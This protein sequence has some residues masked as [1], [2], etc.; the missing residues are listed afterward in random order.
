[1]Q[2]LCK[3][4]LVGVSGSI[5]S[6]S[7]HM[8]LFAF[9]K[10]FAENIKVIM[11]HSAVRMVNPSALELYCDDRVFVDTWDKSADVKTP[12][13][14]L[15]SWADIF[16][17]LPATANILGKAANGVA[18]DLLS[19]AIISSSGT[20]VFAPAMNPLMWAN[21][22]VQRNL[23]M[24]KSDGHYIITPGNGVSVTTRRWDVG[25]TVPPPEEVLRHLQ[26]VRMKTLKDQYWDE[27]TREKPKTPIQRKLEALQ[28]QALDSNV[29]G[30]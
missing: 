2:G 21:K 25:L 22:A 27:A 7:I 17:V 28:E 3:N 8:Y 20:I 19:T 29:N 4:L 13:I 11:T 1:M 9:R 16:V 23:A 18:D 10:A 14:Q 5:G 6:L 24:L 15:T 12:H 30:S 26:H